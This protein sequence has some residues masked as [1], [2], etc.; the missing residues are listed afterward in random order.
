MEQN[1]PIVFAYPPDR[2]T[3]ISYA[4]YDQHLR[5][6]YLPFSS[7]II[8]VDHDNNNLKRERHERHTPNEI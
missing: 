4:E 6:V 5:T 7:F 1:M 8:L 2:Y 3:T